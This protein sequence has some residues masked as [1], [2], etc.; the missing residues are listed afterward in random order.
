MAR[1]KNRFSG[2]GG[3]GGGPKLRCDAMFRSETQLLNDSA[4]KPGAFREQKRVSRNSKMFPRLEVT[5]RRGS[6]ARRRFPLHNS[7][8]QEIAVAEIKPVCS[9][10]FMLMVETYQPRVAYIC[11][12]LKQVFFSC[13]LIGWTDISSAKN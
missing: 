1:K 7:V 3:E 5:D 8:P 9:Q 10:F 2:E 4:W 6:T 11:T 13:V 12:I